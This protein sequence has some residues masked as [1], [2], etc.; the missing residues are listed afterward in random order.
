MNCESSV[1]V[2]GARGLVGSAIVRRLRGQ[3]YQNVLEPSRAALDYTDRERVN[4]YFQE[5]RPEFVF[6]AAARVGGILANRDHPADFIRDNLSIELNVVD[7]SMKHGVTK[8]LMLGSSCIYPR[9]C[10]QPIREEYLLTGPLEPTNFAYA[11]AKIAGITLCQSYM[12]QYG[13]RFISA[14]P[15]NLFGPNDNF[16]LQ[17]SHVIPALMRKFHEAKSTCAEWVSVWGSGTPRREFLYVDDLADACH[18]LMDRY[19]AS[20][21]INVGAG[22]D[23]SIAEL[24]V[25]IADVVG[26]GGEI[27]FDSSKPDG[28]PRKLL[29]V[30]RINRLGWA[31][32]T[33][34]REGLAQTYEW[35]L[36]NT[37]VSDQTGQTRVESQQE[38][39]H[40]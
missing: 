17:S 12:K 7:A 36:G 27:R 25:L 9:D 6:M 2:C 26:Y 23:I 21:H 4:K 19:E 1:L 3:G 8:L 14:M 28:T 31:A 24:A 39:S 29:D 13:A 11:I 10:P 22:K 33:L 32:K 15:T 16:D 37:A 34:L 18:L 30:S 5:N 38:T 20:D 40:R 35:Y